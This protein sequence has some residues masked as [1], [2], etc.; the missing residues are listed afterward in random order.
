[1]KWLIATV[2]ILMLAGCGD[3]KWFPENSSGTSASPNAFPPFPD[4][5]GVAVTN[6]GTVSQSATVTIT[7]NNPSGWTVSVSDATP[8]ANSQFS[9]N[10]AAFTSTAGTILPNQTLRV[11]HTN[12]TTP[13]TITTTNVTVGAFTTTFQST[14]AAQ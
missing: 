12:A 7:G 2:T 6:P 4:V 9:I 8:G 1:M 11:Q 13:S 14:T 10:G 3:V 5:T